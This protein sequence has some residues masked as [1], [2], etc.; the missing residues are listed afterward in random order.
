[1][2]ANHLPSLTPEQRQA[3]SAGGGAASFVDPETRQVYVVTPM[4]AAHPCEMPDDDAVRRQ[5][6]EARQDYRD[7]G[8]PSA[9]IQE[10]L[11]D[12]RQQ[13]AGGS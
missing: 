12:A 10:V 11:A 7:Q 6:E 5:L 3:L 4:S 8:G 1:M 2:D 13:R 9:S